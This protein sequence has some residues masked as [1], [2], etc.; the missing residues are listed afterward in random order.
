MRSVPLTP[1]TL[2]ERNEELKSCKE[3]FNAGP[4]LM[5]LEGFYFYMGA[6]K[7]R[8]GPPKSSILI[9]F[10]L[11][12]TIHFRVP[13]F[14]E[15]PISVF[16]IKVIHFDVFV[17]C[18]VQPD[19]GVPCVRSGRSTPVISIGDKLINPIVGWVVVSNICYFHPYLGK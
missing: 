5:L 14:L 8:S 15:T 18:Q 19:S 7:N 12:F 10:S 1:V 4:G 6:S 17:A 2:A 16:T 3:I 9:G 13:L 11:I